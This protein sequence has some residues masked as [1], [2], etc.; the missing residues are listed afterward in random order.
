MQIHS[1]ALGVGSL[2]V[3]FSCMVSGRT[4]TAINAGI[5]KSYRGVSEVGTF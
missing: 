4:W 5:D 3:T 2:Y 1:E